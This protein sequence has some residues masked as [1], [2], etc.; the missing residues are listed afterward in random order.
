MNVCGEAPWAK[1]VYHLY[2]VRVQDRDELMAKLAQRRY[3][4][5]NSLSRSASPSKAYRHLGYKEG[6]SRRGAAGK[7][8]RLLAH[9]SQSLREQQ[10]RVVDKIRE[11]LSARS[12][13]ILSAA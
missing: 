9:V 5:R 10:Y 8:N 7:R 1:S 4:H 3:R 11:F 13:V 6:I 12:D 2:V